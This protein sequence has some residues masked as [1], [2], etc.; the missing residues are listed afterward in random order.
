ML[1]ILDII[2]DEA[3]ATTRFAC[4]LGACK[5]ACCTMPGGRGAPVDDAEVDDLLAS[6][7]VALAY[8]PER[9]REIIRTLGALEGRAGDFATRCIDNRDC[10]FVYYE[11]DVAKCAV[12]RA[13]VNGETP[14]RKPISCH[15]FPI[16]VS[17]IPGGTYLR[18][19]RIPECDP[20]LD[21]GARAGIPLYRFLKDALTRAFGRETYDALVAQIEATPV[22]PSARRRR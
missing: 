17:E 13:H 6:I 11:N 12:E 7:D 9:N 5:G 8:L 19:E 10:V 4:D 18:Y 16:R 21:N 1:P 22:S 14:F 2:A 15:L 20:A 3:L